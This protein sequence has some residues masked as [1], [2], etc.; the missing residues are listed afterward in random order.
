VLVLAICGATF[1]VWRAGNLKISQDLKQLI[2]DDFPSVVR[3]NELSQRIGSQSEMIVELKCPDREATIKYGES[4]AKRMEQMDEAFLFVEFRRDV[5]WFR[6]NALLFLPIRK[7][8]DLRARVI[9][10]IRDEVESEVVESVDDPEPAATGDPKAEEEEDPLDMDDDTLRERYGKQYDVPTEY[11]ETDDNGTT[12]MVVRGRPIKATTDVEF[13]EKIVARM[14]E[15]LTA[16][17]PTDFHPELTAT[18]RGEYEE[19]SGEVSS[20][21]SELL[22]SSA[23][24]VLLL[25]IVLVLHFKRLR[26]VL[27]I[28]GPLIMS[29][30]LTLGITTYVYVS[31]NLVTAFIFVVLLGL[32]ID[33]G[34]HLYSRYEYERLRGHDQAEALRIAGGHSGL[35]VA[36]G[37]LST[38]VMFSFFPIADFRGFS[39]FGVVAC[40]GVL[41]A[42]LYTLTVLP[43]L[44]VLL[45][46]LK[47]WKPKRWLPIV[48]KTD[49]PDAPKA[50]PSRHWRPV[51]VGIIAVSVALSTY[52]SYKAPNIEFE[53]DFGKLGR[54]ADPKAAPAGPKPKS[55][56]DAI[57]RPNFGPAVAMPETAEEGRL[58]EQQLQGIRLITD[59]QMERLIGEPLPEG[60]WKRNNPDLSDKP[61]PV[62]EVEEEDE[63]DP[64]ATP[65]PDRFADLQAEVDA[66]K[67]APESQLVV[68]TYPIERLREMRYFLWKHLSVWSFVPTQ[69]AVK[70]EIIADIRTR[71]DDKYDEV[72]DDSREKIDKMRKY[73]KVDKQVALEDVPVWVRNR[74]TDNQGVYGR[75][76]IIWNRGAKVDYVDAKRLEVAWFDIKV[77]QK[78]DTVVPLAANYFVLPAIMDTLRRDGP[79]VLAASLIAIFFCLMFMFRSLRLTLLI[80]LPLVAAVTWLA[81][82]FWYL[83][84]K[85]NL[86]NVITFALIIGMGVDDGIHMVSRWVETGKASVALTLRETGAAVA[87][88]TV[89][90]VIGFSGLLLANHVGLSTLGWTAA[91]GMVLCLVAS[92][93]TLPALLY[94]LGARR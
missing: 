74:W 88:T 92:V 75:H 91:L 71:V 63:D 38:A 6:H 39:Q 20:I 1:G 49:S 69:Q 28:L 18:I 82:L 83:E 52:S 50:P 72:S 40:I 33:F 7:L 65:E 47:A 59:A 66:Q 34:I 89:T 24:A 87:L 55:Y 9:H 36:M 64:F 58:V 42:L 11:I 27:L 86:Y 85:L 90:T 32:G 57:G 79:R 94:L 73:L 10:R 3:L 30:L 8:L 44:I 17:R 46:R 5:D 77:G 21:K 54:K 37:G 51:A 25:L 80:L 15:A 12:I 41:A 43:A 23:Y 70:L 22:G 53:Y 16:S 81:G 78:G 29:I 19:R 61:P 84:W 93:T 76:I 13:T 31:L 35:D 68:D 56:E 62:V 60:E 14:K 4:L 67:L 26:A 45:E 2:P 48:A